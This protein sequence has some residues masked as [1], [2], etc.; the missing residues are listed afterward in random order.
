MWEI[1]KY[2]RLKIKR[3]ELN[4][5]LSKIAQKEAEKSERERKNI[6][7]YQRKKALQSLRKS[8]LNKQNGPVLTKK[9]TPP[10]NT[11]DK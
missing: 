10:R 2:N 9:L 6:D 5:E 11:G 8:L 4:L 1:S 7:P 3:N